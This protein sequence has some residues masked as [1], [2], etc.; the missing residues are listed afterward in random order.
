[1]NKVN[2]IL[3]I[4]AMFTGFPAI[5]AFSQNII[6]ATQSEANFPKTSPA[7]LTNL[8][9]Q[10]KL[11]SLATSSIAASFSSI[12]S[13]EALST[14]SSES[15]SSVSSSS[16]VI[17]VVKE[18][19]KP[20]PK[21][22]APAPVIIK[23]E[24]KPGVAQVIETPISPKPKIEVPAPAKAQEAIKSSIVT[25]FVTNSSS[26]LSSSVSSI[27]SNISQIKPETSAVN[28]VITASGSYSDQIIA[29]CEVMGCNSTQMIRIMKCESGGNPTIVGAGLYIGLFQFLPSTFNA[30]KIKAGLPNGNIYNGSDQIH[31]AT[32]MFANGQAS[33]WGCK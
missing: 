17:T 24:I 27:V 2:I 13:L 6:T 5:V 23:Q 18:E 1:M 21:I 31:V 10:I 29:R 16:E 9:T 8:S 30:Y 19:S 20:A 3:L 7:V 12:G 14:I 26:T 25:S 33:Q 22:E 32:Y 4:I 28:S 11:S 15:I